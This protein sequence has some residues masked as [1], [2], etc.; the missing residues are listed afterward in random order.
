LGTTP[1]S[2]RSLVEVVWGV[3]RDLFTFQGLVLLRTAR[4]LVERRVSRS[5]NS[6]ALE[7]LRAQVTSEWP[8]SSVALQ[9]E[10]DEIVVVV[11]VGAA[12]WKAETGSTA[13]RPAPAPSARSVAASR[14]T[15]SLRPTWEIARASAGRPGRA[16]TPGFRC[17]GLHADDARQLTAQQQSSGEAVQ[18]SSS[19]WRRNQLTSGVETQVRSQF[20]G[21]NHVSLSPSVRRGAGTREAC[22]PTGARA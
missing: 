10:C 15:P 1:D 5:R 19:E 12:R 6:R 8:L 2:A 20:R 4:G 18:K 17:R 7:K 21:L 9:Q 16:G 22:A 3:Q 13:F 14:F 11:G